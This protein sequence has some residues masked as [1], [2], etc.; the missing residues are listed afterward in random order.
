[1]V[2]T[3]SLL[4]ARHKRNVVENKMSPLEV[5]LLFPW[6][7]HLK[8]HPHLYVED[9]W[10]SFSSEKRVGGRKEACDRKTNALL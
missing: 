6:T 1:M 10:P 9:K 4:C 8:G 2:F 5:R 3:A 7:R